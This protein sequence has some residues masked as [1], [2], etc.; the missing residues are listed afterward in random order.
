MNK[1]KQI[2]YQELEGGKIRVI[3]QDENTLTLKCIEEE[4]FTAEEL[5]EVVI[6][7]GLVSSK[8]E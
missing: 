1:V 4:E 2:I 6:F 3:L 7:V 5:N 8:I